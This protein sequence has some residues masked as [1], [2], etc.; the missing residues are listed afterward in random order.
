MNTLSA[1]DLVVWNYNGA[2]SGCTFVIK[3]VFDGG[4]GKPRY[5]LT[6]VET[7]TQ[8]YGNLLTFNELTK[9]KEL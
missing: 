8:T 2:F 5:S 9:I 6:D 1:G 7:K 4:D 3:S